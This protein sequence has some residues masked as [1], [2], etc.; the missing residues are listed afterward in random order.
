MYYFGTGGYLKIFILFK[1]HI[2]NSICSSCRN[3]SLHL[4]EHI[5]MSMKEEEGP[6]IGK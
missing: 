4:N 3:E 1:N 6:G 2:S 5:Y